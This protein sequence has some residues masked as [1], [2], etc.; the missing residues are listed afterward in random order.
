MNAPWQVE[1]P[2]QTA[3]VD[4]RNRAGVGWPLLSLL[5][6]AVSVAAAHICPVNARSCRCRAHLQIGGLAGDVRESPR[7]FILVGG[8]GH[9]LED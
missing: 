3:A 9:V 6:P 8:V 4:Q 5:A 7:P 2:G 1:H